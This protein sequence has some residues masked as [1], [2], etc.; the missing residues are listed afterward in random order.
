MSNSCKDFDGKVVTEET[1]KQ[2]KECL[3]LAMLYIDRTVEPA[4]FRYIEPDDSYEITGWGKDEKGRIHYI[5]RLKDGR[6]ILVSEIE[7][8][9]IDTLLKI[10][11]K[12]S[13]S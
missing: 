13:K 2:A 3:H 5:L 10:K 1:I 11:K 8:A 6:V 4:V 12:F 9:H 7:L